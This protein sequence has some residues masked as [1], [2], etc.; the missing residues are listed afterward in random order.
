MA[1]VN[2]FS[3]IPSLWWRDPDGNL[4]APSGPEPLLDDLDVEMPGI[5]WDLL[6]MDRY[7]A[8]NWHCFDHIGER[9]PYAAIHTSLGCPYRCSFCCINAPFGTNA[10]RLW[11]PESVIGNRRD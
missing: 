6:P 8:H 5:A 7:R 9:A 11:S 10:Y 4:H 1:G 2:Q 3:A